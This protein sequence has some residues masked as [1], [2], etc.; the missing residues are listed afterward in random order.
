MA[1]LIAVVGQSGSGKSTSLRNLNEQETFIINVA[2]KPLPFKGFKRRYQQ[3]RKDDTGKYVGNLINLSN[4]E[5]INQILKLVDKT[6]PEIKQV[7]IEDAQYIMAFEAMDRAEE[8]S[9]DKFTQIAKHFYSVLKESVKMRDDLKIVVLTHSENVGDSMN[10]Q[11]KMK[12]VGKM[13]DNV[14]TLEG[15]FTYVLFTDIRV[16]ATDDTIHHYFVTKS[17]GSTTAKTPMECFDTVLI[18][19]DLQFVINKI[20]EF[21]EG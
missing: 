12:T 7:I 14:I 11:W 8:K 4:V 2:A 3:L 13:L 15:L 20:D 1:E 9:Y 16:D 5:Q 18:D 10:P 21:N 19:N 17:D 6:R